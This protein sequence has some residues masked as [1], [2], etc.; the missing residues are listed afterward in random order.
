MPV[1]PEGNPSTKL[2]YFDSQ[3]SVLPFYLRDL[4]WP[5]S[6]TI[7]RTTYVPAGLTPFKALQ[8]LAAVVVILWL[9]IQSIAQRSKITVAL[10]FGAIWLIPTSSFQ[11]LSILYD[12]TRLYLAVAALSW[13]MMTFVSHHR[14]RIILSPRVRSLTVATTAAL[15]G[16]LSLAETF[17]FSSER[18]VWEAALDAD[19][20]TPRA[21]YMLGYLDE[22]DRAYDDAE[23]HYRQ[24]LAVSPTFPSPRL[25]LGILLGRKGD[26]DG[27]SAEFEKLLSA[28]PYWAIRAHYHL[29]LAA[30]YRG[31]P[32]AGLEHIE[33][34]RR[35]DPKHELIAKGEKILNPH[36]APAKAMR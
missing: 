19:P 35:L 7:D 2:Q 15:F 22:L 20:S 5:D 6:L 3:L 17:R 31:K 4:F 27:A 9:V 29:A 34:I 16:M 10:L 30:L 18:N 11:P 21:H 36:L 13:A 25:N 26:L 8:M 28:P 14:Q 12:E 1:D 32:T 24:S 33:A 23:K